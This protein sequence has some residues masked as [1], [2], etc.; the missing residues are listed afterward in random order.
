MKIINKKIVASLCG[1][2]LAGHSVVKSPVAMAAPTAADAKAFIDKAEKQ[3]AKLSENRFRALWVQDTFITKD[4]QEIAA[5][6][7]E[8]FMAA[9]VNLANEAK[10]FS[11]VKLNDETRRKLNRLKLSLLL[12]APSDPAKIN[13]LSKLNSKLPGMYGMYGKA[14]YSRP[15]GECLFE[16]DM[17]KIIGNSRNADELLEVWK[18][19]RHVGSRLG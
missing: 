17:S 7:V 14:K 10:T 15:S 2:L 5:S 19:W 6:A 3:L 4:S 11:D 18:G 16:G 9:T 12:P 1:L 13:E 8:A